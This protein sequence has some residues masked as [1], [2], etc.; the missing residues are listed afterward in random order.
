MDAIE[1]LADERLLELS[2]DIQVQLEKG[3]ALRPVAYMLAEARKKAAKAILLFIDVDPHDWKLILRLQNEIKVYDDMV[4]A[5][6]SVIAHGEDA[7]HR[8]TEKDRAELESIVR[9]MSPEERRLYNMEPRR[10]D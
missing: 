9:D 5:A 8:I 1:R 6:R 4:T 2:T 3:T 7:K 10:T